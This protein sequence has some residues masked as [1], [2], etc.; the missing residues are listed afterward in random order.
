MREDYNKGVDF[1]LA[2]NVAFIYLKRLF[3]L[4]MEQMSYHEG[5]KKLT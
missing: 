3:H 4:I 2:D 1:L 5:T